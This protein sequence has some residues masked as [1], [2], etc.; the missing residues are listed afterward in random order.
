MTVSVILPDVYSGAE[1]LPSSLPVVQ[2]TLELSHQPLNTLEFHDTKDIP[3]DPA[4]AR[5][6]DKA[7]GGS[8]VRVESLSLSCLEG[9]SPPSLGL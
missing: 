9:P 3:Q 5:G 6:Q 1:V 7:E 2:I 8:R 4:G